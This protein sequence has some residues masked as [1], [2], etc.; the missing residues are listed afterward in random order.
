[1]VI[2]HSRYVEYVLTQL[3]GERIHSKTIT[4]YLYVQHA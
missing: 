3:L 4:I 1:M 2:K